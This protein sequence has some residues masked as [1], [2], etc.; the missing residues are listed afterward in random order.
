MFK[1]RNNVNASLDIIIV[2][3]NAGNQLRD[4]LESITATGRDGF[5]LSHVVVVDNG[6]DD[7]SLDGLDAFSLPLHIIRNRENRG[8]AAASNQGAAFCD[9][10]YLLFLNPDTRLFKNS[11]SGPFL[12]MDN[13]VNREVGICGVQLVDQKG[14]I[15]RSCSRFPT[16][17]RFV[18]QSL[19]L[20]KLPLFRSAGVRMVDWDHSSSRSVDQVIGAFFFTRRDV[21]EALCGFDERFF[22]YFEEVDFSL[23]AEQVGWKTVY[24][25]DAQAFHLGGGTTHQVKSARLFYSLRSRVQYGFKQFPRRKAWLLLVVTI[26]IEPVS[27]LFF[28]LTQRQWSNVLATCAGYTMLW[29]EVAGLVFFNRKNGLR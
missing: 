11:L 4:C 15:A 13:D 16:L 17:T 29:R 5:T 25:A 14:D 22:V 23:R 6:S 28:C 21:F 8:F 20:T 3:W 26:L 18:A 10:H 9:A 7:G 24:L 1:D 27:R 19:G 2:N 12:F